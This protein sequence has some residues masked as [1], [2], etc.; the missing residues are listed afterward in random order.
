MK[1]LMLFL[2]LGLSSC[3]TMDRVSVPAE[4]DVLPQNVDQ[5]VTIICPHKISVKHK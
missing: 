4:C 1:L 5:A 2:F 3:G